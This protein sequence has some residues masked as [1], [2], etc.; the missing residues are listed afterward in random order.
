MKP[1]YIECQSV[2]TMH[3]QGGTGHRSIAIELHMTNDQVRAA[4]MDMIGGMTDQEGREWFRNEMPEW[5][6][7]AP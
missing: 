4:V 6:E 5:F 7:V 1:V 3:P 2:D